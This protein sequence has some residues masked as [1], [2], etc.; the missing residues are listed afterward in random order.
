VDLPGDS[1]LAGPV[2]AGSF[3]GEARSAAG[4]WPGSCNR[5]G[6]DGKP[7]DIE[8]ACVKKR[9]GR[10]GKRQSAGKAEGQDKEDR[11][12]TRDTTAIDKRTAV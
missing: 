5:T 6:F 8:R 9:K 7:S 1:G 10:N 2:N 11:G 12:A 3:A 4:Q